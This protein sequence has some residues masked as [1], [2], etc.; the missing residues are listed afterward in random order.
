MLINFIKKNKR[1]L[2]LI[3]KNFMTK[4]ILLVKNNSINNEDE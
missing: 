1:I 3:L 4:S 2:N